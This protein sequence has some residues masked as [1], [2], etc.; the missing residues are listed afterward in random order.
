MKSSSQP[1]ERTLSDSLG[2]AKEGLRQ[3]GLSILLLV[4]GFGAQ[5]GLFVWLRRPMNR[6]M[7][8]AGRG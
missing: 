4:I 8:V 2:H 6:K 5:V 7:T 3:I 1:P